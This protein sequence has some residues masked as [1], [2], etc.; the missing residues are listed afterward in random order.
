MGGWFVFVFF[1]SSRRRHT[2]CREVSWARRCVQETGY[3]RRV[4]GDV[5]LSGFT[6]LEMRLCTLLSSSQ[7][8]VKI[9]I[10][11]GVLQC[12]ADILV[13]CRS[14]V[15]QC[16]ALEAISSL[17]VQE[18]ALDALQNVE[19]SI[20]IK[21]EVVIEEEVKEKNSKSESKH[22]HKH[23]KE[24]EKSH[25]NEKSKDSKKDKKKSSKKRSK[26]P[27]EVSVKSTD[28]KRKKVVPNSLSEILTGTSNLEI[29][30]LYQ[31]MLAFVAAKPPAFILKLV[32]N[33]CLLYT[34]PS[35]RDLSTSR[36]PSSA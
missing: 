15:I 12:L 32:K 5:C 28:H 18:E 22:K 23:K 30:T 26:S 1:F 17:V 6:S 25:K 2:R 35:P 34:S 21:P 27:S 8:H 31:L 13:N 33:I 14:Q 11:K 7:L 3:Q 36:M 9:L 20:S 10:N 29:K 16:Q 19:L 24:K 4:H